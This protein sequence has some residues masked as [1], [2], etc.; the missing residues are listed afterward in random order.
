L[1]APKSPTI[2]R[3][4]RGSVREVSKTHLTE[5]SIRSMRPADELPS[6]NHVAI[7]DDRVAGLAVRVTISGLKIFSWFGRIQPGRNER[8]TWLTLGEWGQHG[9]TV[10]QARQL[11]AEV[12]QRV[13]AGED[14]EALRRE[15]KRRP[16]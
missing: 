6:L 2:W 13:R 4:Y 11:A 7:F 15:L 14:I 5:A 3:D 12:R 16:R 8:Q 1:H 9:L 10:R